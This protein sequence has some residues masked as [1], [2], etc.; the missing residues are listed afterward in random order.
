MPEAALA[1][2]ALDIFRAAASE[3][4]VA[5]PRSESLPDMPVV[6]D[7]PLVAPATFLYYANIPTPVAESLA[8]LA[9]FVFRDCLHPDVHARPR[10]LAP[11][12]PCRRREG[13]PRV[14]KRRTFEDSQILRLYDQYQV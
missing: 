11:P 8:L 13:H 1:L 7:I 12:G 2:F 10:V 14:R 5:L 9:T 3:L 4:I 6:A